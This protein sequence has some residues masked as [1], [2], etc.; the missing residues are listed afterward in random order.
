MNNLPSFRQL[1]S[2]PDDTHPEVA[3][4][5]EFT[6]NGLV[7]HEQ[8]FA[9]LPE[10]ISSQSKT[11]ASNAVNEN[12]T[13]N[14]S[15]TIIQATNVIGS[16]NDQTGLTSYATQQSDYGAFILLSDASAIAV[17]LTTGTAITL[18][19]F[20]TFVNS[21]A[22]T[23]TLTPA[24]GTINGAGLFT[25]LGGQV[26]TVVYDGVNFEI[27][28]LLALPVNTPAV[29]HEWLASYN[30]TTGA[31]TLTQPAFT[32][33][34]GT[35]TPAQ[36]PALSALTGQITESQLPSAGLSV[37]IV[38]AQLTPTGAQGSMTFTN[39]ILTAQ[40]PAT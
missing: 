15:T 31:F 4:A 25:L 26:V 28:P 9:A 34:S 10:Q 23:A 2:L 19:W 29:A 36:V 38:T 17:S 11:A 13:S 8:A 27:C 40:T 35:A 16:V 7:N 14:S 22:G 37:T 5:I 18:P 3:R 30:S 32:D 20:A 6:F 21:G 1:F 24:S 33:I 39:G 12:I